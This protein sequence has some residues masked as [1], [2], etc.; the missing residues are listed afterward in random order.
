MFADDPEFAETSRFAAKIIDGIDDQDRLR[1]ELVGL[2]EALSQNTTGFIGG[3]GQNRSVAYP[4][5]KPHN[6]EVIDEERAVYAGG[7]YVLDP[8]WIRYRAGDSG[9]FAL[10]DVMPEGFKETEYFR[11]FYERHGICD[12]LIHL[13]IIPGRG[14]VLVGAV[15]S[16]SGGVFTEEEISRHEAVHPFVAA[17]SSRCSDLLYPKA[18]GPRSAPENLSTAVEAFGAELLTPRENQVIGLVLSGHNTQSVAVQLGITPD[19]VKLH[20]KHAYAKLRVSSQG[21]LF[22]KFLEHLGLDTSE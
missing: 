11:H 14:A 3:Y 9:F 6:G 13:T 19:T 12:E 10:H 7:A 15:K 5:I 21:E 1:D 2:V 4:A 20:R 18:G 22:F 8:Y 17:C 16:G